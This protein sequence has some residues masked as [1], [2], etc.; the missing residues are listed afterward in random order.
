M[1][2]HRRFEDPTSQQLASL[3]II[4]HTLDA[5][6]EREEYELSKLLNF[7]AVFEKLDSDNLQKVFTFAHA[8]LAEQSAK[9]GEYQKEEVK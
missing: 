5:L 3:R 7:R 2:V 1:L 8:L 6:C 9:A 4:E